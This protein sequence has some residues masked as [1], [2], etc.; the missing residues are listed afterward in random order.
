VKSLLRR[1]RRK[2]AAGRMLIERNGLSFINRTPRRKPKGRILAYHGIGTPEWGVNDLAPARFARQ[3]ELVLREGYR[4]V[5]ASRIATGQGEAND[6]AITFDDGLLTVA[7]NAAPVLAGYG[8]PWTAFVVSD[9]ADGNAW[10]HPELLMTWRQIETIMAAG[11]TVQSHSHTHPDFG[12]I[13]PETT[14]LQL[15]KS[16]QIIE[17]RLGIEVREFAIPFGKAANWTE[18]AQKLAGEAGYET[19]YS[20]CEDQRF[21][22]TV[23]RTAVTVFD[24]DRLFLAALRGAFDGWQEWV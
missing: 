6:L 9:W 12:R 24:S 18:I 4:I 20:Y 19:V 13:D 17:S 7:T 8:V 2:I 10:Y 21:P 1:G 22:G 5:P 23:G 11:A 3:V 14:G 15:E 16:R